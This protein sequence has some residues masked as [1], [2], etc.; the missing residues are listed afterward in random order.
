MKV[1]LGPLHVNGRPHIPLEEV[2]AIVARAPVLQDDPRRREGDARRRGCAAEV[3]EHLAGIEPWI[4]EQPPEFGTE[5]PLEGGALLAIQLSFWTRSTGLACSALPVSRDV[6][7]CA[8]APTVSANPI[9]A[10]VATVGSSS[11]IE[12]LL[13]AISDPPPGWKAC[14]AWFAQ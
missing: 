14:V 12:H 6:A 2:I 8:S 9:A 10:K 7:G 1:E 5:C 11:P 13:H 3:S 4:V